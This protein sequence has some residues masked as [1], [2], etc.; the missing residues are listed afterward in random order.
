MATGKGDRINCR[1]LIPIPDYGPGLS[2]H[3]RTPLQAVQGRGAHPREGEKANLYR[4]RPGA[5]RAVKFLRGRYGSDG[6][7]A[8]G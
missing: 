6:S 8:P 3:T 7:S 4:N 2:R 5:E 1:S